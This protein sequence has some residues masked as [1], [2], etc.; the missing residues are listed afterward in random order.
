[1]DFYYVANLETGKEY[2]VERVK[3]LYHKQPVLNPYQTLQANSNYNVLSLYS[4]N[5]QLLLLI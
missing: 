4:K 5:A 2:S 3:T 1:M